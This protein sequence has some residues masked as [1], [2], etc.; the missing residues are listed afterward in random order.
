[1]VR[2]IV[3]TPDGQR[4]LAH[5]NGLAG[6]ALPALAVDEPF[7]DWDDDRSVAAARVVGAPVEGG[8]EVVPGYWEVRVTG[9][10]PAI[11]RTW[12]AIED[13]SRLGADAPAVRTWAATGRAPGRPG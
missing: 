11:G 12:V 4:V 2:L 3:G 5:P 1:M 13:A 6:W 7:D 8:A 10:V 9:R